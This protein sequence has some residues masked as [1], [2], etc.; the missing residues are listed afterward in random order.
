MA[1]FAFTCLKAASG[2]GKSR[3]RRPAGKTL[4]RMGP[5]SGEVRG[6]QW[7]VSEQGDLR[8]GGHAVG[9]PGGQLCGRV[10]VGL[11]GLVG[12]PSEEDLEGQEAEKVKVS[13]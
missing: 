2:E 3:K 1:Q 8:Y 13:P 6:A 11:P 4:G 12:L 10:K 7:G 9:K 5:R